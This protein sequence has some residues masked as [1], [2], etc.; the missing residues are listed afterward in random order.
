MPRPTFSFIFAMLAVFGLALLT[1]WPLV[2][3][4]LGE[5][6]SVRYLIG[7]HQWL[8]LGPHAPYI[9][10]RVL[11]PG[12][13]AVGAGLVH[14]SGW[15]PLVVL[16]VISFTA[17]VAS[18]P[19]L[20]WLGCKLTTPTAAAVGA[21][22]ILVAPGYW[23]LGIEPHP[24]Q[25]AIALLLSALLCALADSRALRVAA[26]L[27]FAACL[28]CK[29]DMILFGFAFPAFIWRRGWKQRIT[30]LG[31]PAAALLL[32]FC[33]R[34][35]MLQ[36]VWGASQA[37][38]RH[39]IFQFLQFPTGVQALKQVV[40]VFFTA[41]L[42]S[43]GLIAFGICAGWRT[44]VWRQRWLLPLAAWLL[45]GLSFW[46]LIRGN[47][48]RH[49]AALLILPLWAACDACV[50]LLA[51]LHWHPAWAL[52]ALAALVVS[53]NWVAVPANSNLTLY[54]SANVFASAHDL[55][56]RTQELSNWL[57]LTHAR[58]YLGNGT[59]PYIELAALARSPR[60]LRKPFGLRYYG[61]FAAQIGAVD[62]IEANSRTEYLAA[63]RACPG[64]AASLEYTAS[65]AHRRFLG[66]EW[67]TLP[68]AR[69]WYVAAAATLGHRS[70]AR[71][72][73]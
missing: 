39:A 52:P 47:S 71:Q 46:L 68:L 15:S 32:F 23:W 67:H 40:P 65:G 10:G 35:W 30:A 11:S 25:L 48:A 55:A 12:Y 5:S 63:A 42:A 7:L 31:I 6:D 16:N 58:C 26:V 57:A 51:Q 8:R 13:Y 53:L 43:F 28:L 21:G 1:R 38:T 20:V 54:P 29:S 64:A 4:S 24:Q 61:D 73:K 14:C 34:A 41:G 27:F 72:L 59:L 18:A 37:D 66:Q 50:T 45:P 19:L 62:F 49:M 9:Y 22:L 17:A 69:R 70:P 56:N 3:V 2:G 60:S 36:Q 44:S 33:G